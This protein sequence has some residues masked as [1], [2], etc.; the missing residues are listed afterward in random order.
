M[1]RDFYVYLVGRFASGTAL[2]MLRTVV[3][4]RLA[5]YDWATVRSPAAMLRRRPSALTAE[6]RDS[7]RAHVA[8]AKKLR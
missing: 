8:D 7:L 2:T 1:P 6:A 3:G 5:L 4:W